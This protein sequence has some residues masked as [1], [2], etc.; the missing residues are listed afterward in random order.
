MADNGHD[1]MM[2]AR[3]GSQDAKAI[4]DIIVRDAL[5]ERGKNWLRLILGRVFHALTS[6]DAG[7][8]RTAGQRNS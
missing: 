1:V 7:P 8:I 3:L 6:G 4:L 2:T 5:D